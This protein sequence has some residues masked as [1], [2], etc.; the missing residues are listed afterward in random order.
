MCTTFGDNKKFKYAMHAFVHTDIFIN[1]EF[2]VMRKESKDFKAK[3]EWV[4]KK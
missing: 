4:P 2:L 3:K 1:P